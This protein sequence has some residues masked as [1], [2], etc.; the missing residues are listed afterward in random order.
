MQ[1]K[2][3]Q[4]PPSKCLQ[5]T[6]PLLQLTVTIT[7]ENATDKTV[8]Y[9]SSNPDVITVSENGLVTALA[10]GSGKLVI[11][12]RSNCVAHL[13]FLEIHSGETSITSTAGQGIYNSSINVYGGKLTVSSEND[14]NYSAINIMTKDFNIYGGETRV[15]NSN[16][17]KLS[18]INLGSTPLTVCGGKLFASCP[19]G[20]N[21]NAISGY[22]KSGTSKIKFYSTDTEDQW[23]TGEVFSSNSVIHYKYVKAE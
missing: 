11:S 20:E 10:E 4:K 9:T 23:G 18:A 21:V 5:K 2:L 7:P 3:R 19:N 16:T 1:V 14:T 6:L 13:D 17:T 15:V 8:T 22:V 12:F